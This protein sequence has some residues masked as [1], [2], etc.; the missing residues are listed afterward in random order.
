MNCC[1]LAPYVATTS[2]STIYFAKRCSDEFISTTFWS[3]QCLKILYSKQKSSADLMMT[4][5]D[6][7][8]YKVS[9]V[10]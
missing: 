10:C 3:N 5:I 2:P 4:V 7:T 1:M 9:N 8:I 6:N